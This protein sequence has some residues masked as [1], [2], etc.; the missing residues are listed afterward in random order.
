MKLSLLVMLLPLQ[1]FSQADKDSVW[2][3]IRDKDTLLVMTL[4]KGESISSELIEKD[5]CI[6]ANKYLETKVTHLEREIN[7]DLL[8]ITNL[9]QSL[10]YSNTQ[11]IILK[12]NDSLR[13]EQIKIIEDQFKKE[14]RKKILWGTLG[15][16][17][18]LGV[19]IF[20]GS[21]IK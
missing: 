17:G 16:L 15:T 7:L 10:D 14:R 5:S 1:V 18:G 6:A 13:I 8:E 3:E 19:G 12:E 20:T 2:V 11:I 9:N 21:T 4:E